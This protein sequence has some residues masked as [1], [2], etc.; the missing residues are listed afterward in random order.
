M[1]TFTKPD[2]AA[3][4]DREIV[5][6]TSKPDGTPR[7]VL[8]ISRLTALGWKARIGLEEGIRGTYQWYLE[9][10]APKMLSADERR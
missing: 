1:A 5:F 9:S 6:D 3:S 8:D 10:V 4:S 2:A 7:K